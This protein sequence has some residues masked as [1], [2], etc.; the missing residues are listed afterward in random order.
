MVLA[1]VSVL[2]VVVF[3]LS[4]PLAQGSKIIVNFDEL[5]RRPPDSV[6]EWTPEDVETWVNRTIGYPEYSPIVRRH[7]IDGPTLLMIDV[8]KAFEP[9]HHIHSAKFRAHIDILRGRCVCPQTVSH[10]LWSYFGAHTEFVFR[11]GSTVAFLPR[12]GLLYVYLYD[13]ATYN[14]LMSPS[15]TTPP[16]ALAAGKPADGQPQ[17]VPM[18][19]SVLY[20][21]MTLVAPYLLIAYKLLAVW[22]TNYIVVTPLLFFLMIS[23]LQEYISVTVAWL[24]WKDKQRPSRIVAYALHWTLLIPVAAWIL[25]FVLP[26]MVM[27]ALA[28]VFV[29]HASLLSISTVINFI[30]ARRG[31]SEKNE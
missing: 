30:V 26:N 8:D 25:A 4:A 3:A 19:A 6:S 17:T 18:Y 9:K 14:A 13:E 27:Q 11:L 21:V 29:L 23:Q 16:D 7:L 31:G 2:V 20:V 15:P 12:T 5:T 28:I 1:V 10:D 24:M 22:T